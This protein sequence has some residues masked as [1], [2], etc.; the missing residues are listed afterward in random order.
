M[1]CY[2]ILPSLRSEICRQGCVIA[3][4]VT[5]YMWSV[6]RVTTVPISLFPPS[7]PRIPPRMVNYH[8]P[9]VIAQNYSM[10]TFVAKHTSWWS[11]LTSFGSG[12]VEALACCS[13]ALLVC[14]PFDLIAYRITIIRY[15]I[16]SW[17]FVTTLDYEWRVFRKRLPFRW[18]IWVG[19][20]SRFMLGFLPWCWLH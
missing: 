16:S 8:D 6:L 1:H 14:L 10:Y 19:D 17:E 15:L 4:W 5:E 20:N 3:Q 18:T 13:W 12:I 2:R 7:T 9:A 11:Q